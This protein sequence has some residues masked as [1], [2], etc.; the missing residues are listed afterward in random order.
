MW[1]SVFEIALM[2]VVF[3][4]LM[5]LMFKLQNYEFNRLWKQLSLYFCLIFLAYT[6]SVYIFTQIRLSTQWY[7]KIITALYITNTPQIAISCGVVFL[8]DNK[9][10]LQELSKLDYLVKISIFQ[11]YRTLPEDEGTI[12][13][14]WV[15]ESLI[16][17]L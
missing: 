11:R 16:F 12:E 4:V 3:I 5:S 8:K 9:D 7:N 10:M 15:K 6:F 17:I 14:N 13:F 2:T 1:F